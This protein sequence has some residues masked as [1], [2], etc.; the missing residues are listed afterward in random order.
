MKIS[1]KSKKLPAAPT[2]DWTLLIYMAGDNDL[3][4]FGG[5]DLT[6]MKKV[7]SS[8]KLH[9]IVQRD[10]AKT[11]QQACRYRVRKGTKISDDVVQ[12]M[13]R[14]NTGDPAVLT[15]FLEWGLRTYP[16]KR[17]MAVLWN[18]GS[19]WDDTDI[20]EESRRRGLNPAPAASPAVVAGARR[21]AVL[22][23]SGLRPAAF[24]QRR[25]HSRKRMRSPFFLTAWQT[26]VVRGQRRAIAFDDDAQD[27]LDSVEMK[28]VFTAVVKKAGRPFDVIGMDACLMSMV[29]TGLQVQ[30]SGAVCCGSQEIEPGDGWPYDRIL[31]KLAANPAMDGKAL[32]SLIA[33]EFVASYSRDE[34]VTQSAF[35][36]A[37]LPKVAQAANALGTLLAKAWNKADGKARR[38]VASARFDSQGYDHEDYVDLQDFAEKLAAEY[39]PAAAAAKAIQKAITACVFANQAVHRKV[40][41]SRGL[42]IY[43][44]AGR[45][46]SPLYRKLD[47]GKGGWAAFLE[48]RAAK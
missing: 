47:F 38:A 32:T 2:A 23:S 34:P 27:F 5:K 42:S 1:A 19:G 31:A 11:G 30:K 28:N 44:P 14:I 25:R 24:V 45:E 29:E 33:K 39:P 41:N 10:T 43:L 18:H 20:Y 36:L 16:A 13:G 17:T 35:T 40:K 48:A 21:R 22:P 46:V 8:D 7:G 26:G 12:K 3:D 15:D 9:I 4:S 37:A 6:E